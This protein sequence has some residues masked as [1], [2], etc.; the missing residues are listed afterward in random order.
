[1]KDL[2]GAVPKA[3]PIN[4]QYKTRAKQGKEEKAEGEADEA[5]DDGEA[6]LETSKSSDQGQ[7]KT[8]LKAKSVKKNNQKKE[9][10]V[11][12]VK[13]EVKSSYEPE[14]YSSRRNE[15]IQKLRDGGT[16]YKLACVAWNLSPMKRELLCGLSV[17]ELK[18]RR[19]LPKGAD[20]NPWSS[21]KE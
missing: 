6:D 2:K 17:S 14:V 8:S 1:M 10:K 13:V 9:N 4:V 5:G 16:D 11:H 18:R 12:K 21:T 20:T 19:F 7:S 3:F 15:F